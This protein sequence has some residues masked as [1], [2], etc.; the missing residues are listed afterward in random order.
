MRQEPKPFER[1]TVLVEGM[2]GVVTREPKRD[3]AGSIEVL[4][5]EGEDAS[6]LPDMDRDLDLSHHDMLAALKKFVSMPELTEIT[7]EHMIPSQRFAC[8]SLTRTHFPG[9]RSAFT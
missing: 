9:K 4:L 1:K 2:R 7:I 8:H 6:V 3:S 5:S